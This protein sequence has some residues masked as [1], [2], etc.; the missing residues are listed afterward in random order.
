MN[1]TTQYHE[2]FYYFSVCYITQL[3]QTTVQLQQSTMIPTT[4]M[5]WKPISLIWWACIYYIDNDLLAFMCYYAFCINMLLYKI[6]CAAYL[7]CIKSSELVIHCTKYSC[8]GLVV[9]AVMN[10]HFYC[11]SLRAVNTLVPSQYRKC[12]KRTIKLMFALL[13]YTKQNCLIE[14][15]HFCYCKQ[16]GNALLHVW[17]TA[18]V[19]SRCMVSSR[20]WKLQEVKHLA[21]TLFTGTIHVEFF[22]IRMVC[23]VHGCRMRPTLTT[24]GLIMYGSP[25]SA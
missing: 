25:S 17:K 19:G 1:L 2:K 7:L 10:F 15:R 4:L 6:F 11:W 23:T 12:I 20:G 21:L 14:S 22:T 3:M 13:N 5:G 9:W 18:G 16:W 24:V 8:P